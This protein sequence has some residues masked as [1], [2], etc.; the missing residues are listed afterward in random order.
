[1]PDYAVV[2]G[3]PARVRGYVC[4][5]CQPLSG[6]GAVLTCEKCGLRYVQDAHGRG[7]LT[8]VTARA[9]A[10]GGR[11]GRAEG[12]ARPPGPRPEGGRPAGEADATKR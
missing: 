9:D 3:N 4:E 6:K 11:Q 7:L 2:V 10:E 8:G 12:E 5:C 1:M